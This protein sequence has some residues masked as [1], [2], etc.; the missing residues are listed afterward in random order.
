MAFLVTGIETANSIQSLST[1]IF[2]IVNTWG[3]F[4]VRCT[5]EKCAVVKFTYWLVKKFHHYIL[6]TCTK[7]ALTAFLAGGKR[8]QPEDPFQNVSTLN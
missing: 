3:D 7:I 5:V 8:R 1:S 6:C 2:L 4:S